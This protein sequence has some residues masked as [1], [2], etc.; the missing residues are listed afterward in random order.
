MRGSV[1]EIKEKFNVFGL[2]YDK[3][4]ISTPSRKTREVAVQ[5]L[6]V[7]TFPVRIIKHKIVRIL[8]QSAVTG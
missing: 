6:L 3:S 2:V 8:Q 7:V 5:P 4:L 1:L